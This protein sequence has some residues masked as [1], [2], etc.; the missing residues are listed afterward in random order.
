MPE[1][2]QLTPLD[3]EEQRF[4]LELLVNVE[5]VQSGNLVLLTLVDAAEVKKVPLWSFC[6]RYRLAE[7]LQTLNPGWC[8]KR[9][10]RGRGDEEWEA[11]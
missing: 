7:R 10:G 6:V 9:G 1:P 2:P 3:M 8:Q 4:Y 11:L 5:V